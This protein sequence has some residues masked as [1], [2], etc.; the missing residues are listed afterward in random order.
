MQEL[1][2]ARLLRAATGITRRCSSPCRCCDRHGRR[3][4]RGTRPPAGQLQRPDSPPTTREGHDAGPGRHT[5]HL[6][7]RG[8]WPVKAISPRMQASKSFTYAAVAA[9]AAWRRR[10]AS[11]ARQRT[12]FAAPFFQLPS[13]L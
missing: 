1:A 13:L 12:F 7:R 3:S 8:A 10:A 5:M 4:V 2:G 6:K 9:A 11:A